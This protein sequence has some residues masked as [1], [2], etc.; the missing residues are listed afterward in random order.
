MLISVCQGCRGLKE[1]GESLVLRKRREYALDKILKAYPL[2]CR[3]GF[4][5]LTENAL[6]AS[7]DVLIPVDMKVKARTVSSL[8]NII[9]QE[10][11]ELE[12]SPSPVRLNHGKLSRDESEWLIIEPLLPK[13]KKHGRGRKQQTNRREIVNAIL[14]LLKE[15]CQWRSLPHDFPH[16]SALQNKMLIQAVRE[17]L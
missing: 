9:W 14:Y 6:A 2:Y 13:V 12:L 17:I 1:V 8:V 7:T 10:F 11:E 3:A 5:L 4:D 15:G 16:W